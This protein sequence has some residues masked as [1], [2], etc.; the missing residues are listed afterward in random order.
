MQTATT[1]MESDSTIARVL[2]VSL[3]LAQKKWRVTSSPGM[4][5]KP[6]EVS[7]AGGATKQLADE[8]MRAKCRFGLEPD[9]RVVC[10]YE[11]GR[12]GF[13]VHRWL[14]SHGVEN[15]VV[16]SSSIEVNRR[17]RRAKSDHLDGRKLWTM[18]IRYE[19]GERDLW[20]VVRVPTV[21][22]EDRRHLHR[23]LGALKK[24]RTR[25]VNRIRGLL[26]SQ[27]LQMKCRWTDFVQWLEKVRLWNGSPLSVGLR[28]RLEQEYERLQLIGAQIKKLERMRTEQIRTASAPEVEK[29]RRLIQL[30]AIG[31]TTAWLYVMEVL[32]W[33][34]IRNRREL[35]GLLGLTPTP[36]QSGTTNHE[37]GISK[38]GI[39]SLRALAIEIA[40]RWLVLQ[41]RSELSRWYMK[42][43]G[44]DSARLRRVGIVALAR[45][46]MIALWRYVDHGTVPAGAELKAV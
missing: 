11:A 31:P 28:T 12:E 38:A 41:P 33:R 45:K 43:F 21:E 23:E 9:A 20:K 25:Q 32:G 22:E 39:R 1:R 10:C 24:D 30:R 5:R 35:G 7:I 4:G 42:R 2:Y 34:E 19:N 13:W 18:L 29:V 3:E 36:Y 15:R 6:R 46:L 8:L 37:Q 14:Q 16:D 44:G 27:G 26:A 17:A 40:W